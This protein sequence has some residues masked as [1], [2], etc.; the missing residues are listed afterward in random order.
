MS[1]LVA[2]PLDGEPAVNPYSL[3]EAVNSSSD[4]AHNAWLIFLA[5][6]TYLTIAVA[7]VTHADLLLETPVSLPILQVSIQLTQFFQFAPVILVLLHVGLVSQLALLARKTLEF[8]HALSLL[9]ASD[10]RNHPLRLEVD[11]FFFVQAIAGPERSTVMSAF[12]HAMSWLTLVLLPVV[13]L[14]YIQVMFLPYHDLTTTWAHR[15]LLVADIVMLSMIG[16]FLMRT[17]TSFARA[18][19][20]T[21]AAHPVRFVATG[22]LM[23]IVLAL[24]FFVATI[25][26]EALD[27]K[28]RSLFGL[29]DESAAVRSGIYQGGFALPF[30]ASKQDGTLF[31]LFSRNLV[32]TDTDLVVDKDV[33][34]GEPTLKL[35][36]R[37]LRFAR[38]D[39]SDL[40]QADLTGADVS[41]ASF[42]GADLRDIWL[43][44]ADVNELLLSDNR[45]RAQCATARNADFSRARLDRA[46][47]TGLDLR[48][49]R[50]EEARLVGAD[51]PYALLTGA[52]FSAARLDMADITGGVQAQGANFLI[53]S[54][55]GADLTGA[56]LQFADFSS[57]GLQGAGLDYANLHGA[58]L[59]DA[60]LEGASLQQARLIGTDMSGARLIGGDLRWA[61]V[62]AASPP[63][64]TSLALSDTTGL[65]VARP[66]EADKAT[67]RRAIDRIEVPAT[68]VLV[69]DSLAPLLDAERNARW[70]GSADE[71]RWKQLAAEGA[72]R[73]A[74]PAFRG[75]LTSHLA[76][77]MCRPRWSDG[78]L[79]TGVAR[80][81][82]S[83]TFR[84]DM[85]AVFDRLTAAS[86]VAGQAVD[87]RIMRS[88]TTAVDMARGVG[89]NPSA[90]GN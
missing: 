29:A 79:A 36:G 13:L 72:A 11:N 57:A 66:T 59:R 68:R 22:V 32:V 67:M 16:V 33:S 44:C 6:M 82:Q 71:Q 49:A 60:D 83:S 26:G 58:V 30:L 45:E 9:E 70:E 84:G 15:I 39:R 47:L 73:S 63:S 53:A 31:G 52:N 4:T 19:A 7:G 48:G 90:G 21:S 81:A 88:L 28:G 51:M 12:L 61:Q 23:C 54:L 2:G 25:P 5:L 34:A 78:G 43:Q 18:F 74:G 37:D 38:L 41:G 27:R 50:L 56:Q 24:S 14:L 55:P 85:V 10:R 75:D 3:L 40:H 89:G 77:A 1:D 46:Q 64:P 17:E 65:E 80:R 20:R 87:A 69:G 86:C 8:N 35:R 62:W 76:S 42:V